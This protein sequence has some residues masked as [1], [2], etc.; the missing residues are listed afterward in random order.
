MSISK[1]PRSDK[2]FLTKRILPYFGVDAVVLR[3]E[4]SGRKWPDCWIQV[5]TYPP[6]ITVTE[7]WRRQTA[8]ERCKRLVHEI[9]HALGIEHGRK[10][11]GLVYS[12]YPERDT[13]SMA[14]FDDILDGSPRFDWRRFGA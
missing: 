11:R 4:K 6:V 8:R 1:I 9:G 2:E 10:G 13:W 7:E 12:L 3:Y 5:N 14:V